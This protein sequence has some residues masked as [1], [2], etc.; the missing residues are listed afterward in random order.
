MVNLE[1][2]ARAALNGEALVLRSLAQDWLN[3]GTALAEVACPSTRDPEILAVAASL[4]ELFA[5]RTGQS[6]PAWTSVVSGLPEAR[7]L[8]RSAATMKNLRR[9]CEEES[10]WP[11][12]RRNLFA[13]ADYLRFA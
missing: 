12:K 1:D 3:A 9:M 13:P 8:V 10:P 7:F 4:V 2:I 11:L 6:A 5:E